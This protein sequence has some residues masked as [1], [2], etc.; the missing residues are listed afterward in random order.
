MSVKVFSTG[1][2]LT[3]SDTNAYLANSGLV[4]IKSQNNVGSNASI[5]VSDCFSSTY[6]NYYIT[7]T[8]GTLS[9]AAAVGCQLG[10]TS[11]SGYN[12]GYYGGIARV[13]TNATNDNLGMDNGASWFYLAVGDTTGV[14]MSFKVFQPFLSTRTRM[15]T[16]WV[17]V[18]TTDSWG[19][20][21]GTHTATS[22]FTGFL[23]AGGA[24]I[25]DGTVAVYGFRKA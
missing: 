13:K 16:E 3:A 4:L 15:F 10:P 14:T 8:G 19:A 5:T 24:N 12:T 20:G 9:G 25:V 2:V 18:R 23:L 17:D 7:L 21:G 6:D 1:E 22:S 11:V